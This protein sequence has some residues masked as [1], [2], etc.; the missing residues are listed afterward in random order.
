MNKLWAILF[1]IFY[2]FLASASN[3]SCQDENG[4]KIISLNINDGKNEFIYYESGKEVVQFTLP[5]ESIVHSNYWDNDRIY[6]NFHPG[7]GEST[8]HIIGRLSKREVSMIDI[9]IR[10]MAGNIVRTIHQ[11]HCR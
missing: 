8:V 7:W 6:I 5:L 2:S 10:G 1:S 4:N 11:F 9:Y 3:Y